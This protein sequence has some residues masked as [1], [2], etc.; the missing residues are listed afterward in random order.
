MYKFVWKDD[1]VH[2]RLS[3]QTMYM[4]VCVESHV[5]NPQL[6]IKF[7]VVEF[8]LFGRPVGTSYEM[9]RGLLSFVSR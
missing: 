4:F 5:R 3:G 6:R 7:L 2:V 8:R 9:P 1:Y